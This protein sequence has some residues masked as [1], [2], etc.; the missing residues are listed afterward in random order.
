MT[1]QIEHETP[2]VLEG[3]LQFPSPRKA[4]FRNLTAALD[5]CKFAHPREISIVVQEG[6]DC[7]VHYV[8]SKGEE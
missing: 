5:W 4:L 8:L 7:V 1:L 6:G 2:P 3:D